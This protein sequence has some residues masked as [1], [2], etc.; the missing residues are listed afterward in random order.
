MLYHLSN[1]CLRV[2][3]IPMRICTAIS[4][5]I[6]W[7]FIRMRICT[8]ISSS[9]YWSF[10]WIFKLWKWN[11]I[12][13]YAQWRLFLL[14]FQ[15]STWRN[16]L[17]LLFFFMLLLFIIN[18]SSLLGKLVFEICNLIDKLI[19]VTSFLFF[20]GDVDR[21]WRFLFLIQLIVYIKSTRT[22]RLDRSIIVNHS[23]LYWDSIFDNIILHRR[24]RSPKWISIFFF[25]IIV[26]YLRIFFD[27]CKY[28]GGL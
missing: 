12:L 16:W 1:S 20:V 15:P 27:L 6:Y 24:F 5:S 22:H 8:A 18:L 4:T 25:Y 7:S 23:Y 28:S 11:E 21:L 2:I 10:I 9:I 13:D 26:L 3:F 17:L 14:R 19:I